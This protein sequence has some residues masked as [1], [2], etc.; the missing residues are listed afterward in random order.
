VIQAKDFGT[1]AN[2]FII[3]FFGEVNEKTLIKF[4]DIFF[5]RFQAY[6]HSTENMTHYF[7]INHDICINY[8]VFLS[9]FLKALIEP[10]IKCPIRI[11]SI[12]PKMI[13]ISFIIK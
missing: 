10:V 11:S 5:S 4:L 8:S 12:S 1:L 6:Q 7:S 2:E 9:E 3:Y 13:S